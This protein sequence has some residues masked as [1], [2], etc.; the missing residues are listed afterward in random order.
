M[1]G[2]GF[3]RGSQGMLNKVLGGTVHGL[4]PVHKG[5]HVPAAVVSYGCLVGSVG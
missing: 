3:Q 4:P 2:V 1:A 5:Q